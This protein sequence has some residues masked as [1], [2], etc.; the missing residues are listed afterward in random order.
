MQRKLKRYDVTFNVFAPDG[1][2][3]GATHLIRAKSA[4]AARR[5]MLQRIRVKAKAV[6]ARW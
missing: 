2:S 5:K 1:F 6:V 3:I 4:I